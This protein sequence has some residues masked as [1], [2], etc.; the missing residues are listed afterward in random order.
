VLDPTVDAI[1]ITMA[2]AFI[3]GLVFIAGILDPAPKPTER[4]PPIPFRRG[5]F[6]TLQQ[7]ELEDTAA[8]ELAPRSYHIAVYAFAG[9]AVVV[10]VG[11][12]LSPVYMRWWYF[13]GG[14]FLGF[15][16]LNAIYKLALSGKLDPRTPAILTH[17]LAGGSKPTEGHR[18][19]EDTGNPTPVA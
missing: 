11:I 13:I 2:A 12:Y 9:L 8:R 17:V 14:V 7:Q 10:G 15:F 18:N 5:Y 6:K 3:G 16:I 1:V 4:R 19:P